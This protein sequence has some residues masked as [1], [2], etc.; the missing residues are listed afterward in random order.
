MSNSIDRS[1]KSSVDERLSLITGD[2]KKAIRTLSIPMIVSMLLMMFT[3]LL[4]VFG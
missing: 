4:I 1:S 2:P 3:I